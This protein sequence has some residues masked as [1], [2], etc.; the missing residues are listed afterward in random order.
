MPASISRAALALPLAADSIP[1][2]S[3]P[4]GTIIL[5]NKR[6][7][8]CAAQPTTAFQ[9]FCAPLHQLRDGELKQPLFGANYFRVTV[10]PV[11]I[12]ERTPFSSHLPACADHPFLPSRQLPGG[13]DRPAELKITFAEG[14]AVDL[15]VLYT[16]LLESMGALHSTGAMPGKRVALMMASLFY[17]NSPNCAAAGLCAAHRS[18]TCV[19]LV[20][21]LC[22][23]GPLK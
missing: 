4:Q 1:A 6:L 12:I 10:P 22:L 21:A 2:I 5:S 14:G 13:F 19:L 9:S 23:D 7:V 8:F 18:T 3:C 20:R 17:S 15:S 11:R 16:S